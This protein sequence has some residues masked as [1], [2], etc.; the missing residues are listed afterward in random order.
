[1]HELSL[2]EGVLQI[3]VAEAARQG[4]ARV[5]RVRL[6]IGALAG[7]EQEALRFA[8]DVVMA[9]SIADTAQLEMTVAPASGRCPACKQIVAV[10]ERY[11]ACPK[12]GAYGV[13]IT[14]GT[15]MRVLEI[16]AFV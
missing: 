1:M 16:E 8:F 5:T 9:G 7:V 13:E 12:C 15:Q 11:D 6:E 2:A 4:L 10:A 14:E 3:V